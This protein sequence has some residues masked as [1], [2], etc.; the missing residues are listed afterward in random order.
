MPPPPPPSRRPPP[1]PQLP[2]PAPQVLTDSW[3]VGRIRTDCSCP[4][5]PPLRHIF[6][7]LEVWGQKPPP[8]APRFPC[9]PQP[10]IPGLPRSAPNEVTW[11]GGHSTQRLNE[12]FPVRAPAGAHCR[13]ATSWV[14]WQLHNGS[15]AIPQVAVNSAG[16]LWC[17]AV[18]WTCCSGRRNKWGTRSF[19]TVGMWASGSCKDSALAWRCSTGMVGKKEWCITP[20]LVLSPLHSGIQPVVFDAQTLQAQGVPS[21]R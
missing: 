17:G 9:P 19:R 10:S 2:P 4:P 20:A 8:P 14:P 7:G 6:N 11:L 5:P 16:L 1:W 21:C 3:G 18:D 15:Q 13:R 12:R